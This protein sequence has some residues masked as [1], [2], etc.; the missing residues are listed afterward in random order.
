MALLEAGKFRNSPFKLS[1]L[2][3]A[4]AVRVLFDLMCSAQLKP[5]L[6]S[7]CCSHSPH[8]FLAGGYFFPPVQ[9]LDTNISSF[10]VP[11]GERR[12]PLAQGGPWCPAEPKLMQGVTS[13]PPPAEPQP[14]CKTAASS[15]EGALWHPASHLRRS[16]NREKHPQQA[17]SPSIAQL[18]SFLPPASVP[19]LLDVV[20]VE[21]MPIPITALQ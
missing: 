4:L 2:W 6:E 1:V 19:V 3:G 15:S 10:L 11:L 7:I 17:I 16:V 14:V 8:G 20:W 13:L 18:F 5:E 9:N 21:D 12:A